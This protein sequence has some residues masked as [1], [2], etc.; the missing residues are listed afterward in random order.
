MNIGHFAS[1]CPVQRGG[2]VLLSV[3]AIAD[4]VHVLL[5]FERMHHYQALVPCEF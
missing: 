5:A 3:N 4:Y 2:F 1:N